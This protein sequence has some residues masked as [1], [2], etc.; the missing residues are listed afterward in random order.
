MDSPVGLWIPPKYCW[1][2]RPGLCISCYV[3]VQMFRYFIFLPKLGDLSTDC[4]QTLSRVRWWLRVIKLW[5][6]FGA[7]TLKKFGSPKTSKFWCDL[8]QLHDLIVKYLRKCKNLSSVV[9]W[10]WSLLYIVNFSRLM[11]KKWIRVHPI[12]WILVYFCLNSS[13]SSRWMLN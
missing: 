11:A 8:G 5:K 1:W 9:K 6:K 3:L 12:P 7:S 10:H 13:P 2:T 4:H